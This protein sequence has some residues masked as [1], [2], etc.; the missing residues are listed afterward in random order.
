M[1]DEEEQEKRSLLEFSLPKEASP[2]L[3]EV[4]HNEIDAQDLYQP[5][6][7]AKIVWYLV[8]MWF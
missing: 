4:P 1:D 6:G 3:E 2:F 7:L 8:G 5:S